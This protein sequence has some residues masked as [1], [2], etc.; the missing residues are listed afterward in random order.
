MWGGRK[1]VSQRAK[2]TC[3]GAKGVPEGPSQGIPVNVGPEN[4]GTE[5]VK[6]V[7]WRAGKGVR[8]VS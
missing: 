5:E 4:K 2:L 3:L 7:H 6:E 8:I 1:N